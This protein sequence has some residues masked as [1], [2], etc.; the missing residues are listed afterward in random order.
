M[1][2]LMHTI[3]LLEQWVFLANQNANLDISKF[4]FGRWSFSFGDAILRH[5]LCY[6]AWEGSTPFYSQNF[7]GNFK[8][9]EKNHNNSGWFELSP[10]N[11]MGN[12]SIK[13]VIG[14][15]FSTLKL[16]DVHFSK[17][18]Y[19]SLK[20]KKFIPEKR[21]AREMKGFLVGWHLSEFSGE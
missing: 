14:D 2:L 4:R 17:K 20:T 1:V 11:F 7:Y 9:M 3:L 15:D 6:S 10:W 13:V 18:K 21:W 5:T 19:D 16:Y 8:C 12:I